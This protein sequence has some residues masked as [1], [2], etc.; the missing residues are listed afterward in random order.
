MVHV[1]WSEEIDLPALFARQMGKSNRKTCHILTI[2]S[3]FSSNICCPFAIK[4]V[5][6]RVPQRRAFNADPS[7]HINLRRNHR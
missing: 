4:E 1:T 5:S 2:P 7:D 3:D 6:I